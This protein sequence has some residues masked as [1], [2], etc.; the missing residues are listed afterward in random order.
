MNVRMAGMDSVF[1]I[2][3]VLTLWVLIT[4]ASANQ[5]TQETK[6]GDARLREAAEVEPSIHA[7]SMPGAL[8]N[9]EGK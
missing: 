8:R 1:Q 2:P 5:D 3:I 9:G 4:V 7:V 6:S